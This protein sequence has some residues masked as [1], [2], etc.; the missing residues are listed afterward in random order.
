MSSL[1]SKPCLFWKPII[2]AGHNGLFY[3]AASQTSTRICLTINL[4]LKI[5]VE[6]TNGQPIAQLEIMCP[7]FLL[8][9]INYKICKRDDSLRYVLKFLCHIG[10]RF[11][12]YCSVSLL[13]V[14]KESFFFFV[15]SVLRTSHMCITSI[16]FLQLLLY[17]PFL[18]Q[19]HDPFFNYYCYIFIYIVFFC[20]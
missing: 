14:P 7:S 10:K 20:Q 8:Y 6:R 9:F 1:K 19:I 13:L 2:P 5:I 12:S 11:L 4:Y 18:S 15:K 3:S 16:L 17:P